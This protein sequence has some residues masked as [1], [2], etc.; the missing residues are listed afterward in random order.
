[1][2]RKSGDRKKR[3]KNTQ[4][5]T[6]TFSPRDL[7]KCLIYCG[8]NFSII[9]QSLLY[10]QPILCSQDAAFLMRQS[11]PRIVDRANWQFTY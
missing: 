1:M 8:S 5:K 7:P 2:A 6:S 3:N 4:Q 10:K 11:S 9:F